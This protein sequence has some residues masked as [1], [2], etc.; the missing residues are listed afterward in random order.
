M[1]H[2]DR[3]KDGLALSSRNQYLTKQQ[4]AE[5]SILCR[6]LKQA[7]QLVISGE[8]NADKIVRFIKQIIQQNSRSQIDY[9]QCVDANSLTP[10]KKIKGKV[11]IALAVQFGAARLI[12]NIIF[13]TQ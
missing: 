1:H 5:A 3:D 12:D 7:K 13:Y 9:V 11:M 6:S 10:L 4:R 2:L 8:R